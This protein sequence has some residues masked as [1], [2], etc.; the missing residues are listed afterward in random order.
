M[1]LTDVSRWQPLASAWTP[2][3][4]RHSG[5][6]QLGTHGLT[7]S[8]TQ[9]SEQ[10]PMRFARGWH[11]CGRRPTALLGGAAEHLLVCTAWHRAPVT[12]SYPTLPHSG[13]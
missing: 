8:C 11:L 10:R 12:L 3:S 6:A 7:H 5:P 2:A 4:A 9:N 13:K 1:R